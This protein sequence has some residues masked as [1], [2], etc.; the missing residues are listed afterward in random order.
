[1][2]VSCHFVYLLIFWVIAIL[3]YFE[4]CWKWF[5]LGFKSISYIEDRKL[6]DLRI[7]EFFL[8]GA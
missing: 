3:C 4:E 8:I 2:V 1:M 7:L 5:S 6:D